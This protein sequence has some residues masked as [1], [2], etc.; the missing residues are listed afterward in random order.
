MTK[1]KIPN[2]LESMGEYCFDQCANLREVFIPYNVAVI[3][4][5]AFYNCQS[6]NLVEFN[7]NQSTSFI[8]EEDAFAY[9]TS[10][11]DMY[12]PANTTRIETR[13]FQYA[14]ISGTMVL[15]N[16]IT[17]FGDTDN[18]NNPSG[19]F[20][21]ATVK[22][23]IFY[24]N[25][26]T[27]S[28][29]IRPYSFTFFNLLRN[30]QKNPD[31]FLTVYGT[32]TAILNTSSNYTQFNRYVVNDCY[33]PNNVSVPDSII[34]YS[35]LVRIN[36][37]VGDLIVQPLTYTPNMVITLSYPTTNSNGGK[38]FVSL[39]TNICTFSLTNNRK[40][41]ISQAG[42]AI[43]EYRTAGTTIYLPSVTRYTLT[44]SKAFPTYTS[45]PQNT[46]L[47]YGTNANILFPKS[48]ST[49]TW[50]AVSSNTSICS[51]S[52]IT[53]TSFTLNGLHP[54]SVDIIMTQSSTTNYEQGRVMFTATIV[55]ANTV[56]SGISIASTIAYRNDLTLSLLDIRGGVSSNNPSSI[57]YSITDSNGSASDIASIDDATQTISITGT[58]SYVF[59][60]SQP[61]T[62]THN[63]VIQHYNVTVTAGTPSVEDI[64]DINCT[65]GDDTF[66]IN[67][68][69]S[70]SDGEWLILGINN[71]IINIVEGYRTLFEIKKAGAATITIRQSST[72]K[73]NDVTKY[74]K[75]NVAK[76]D[77]V[78]YWVYFSPIIS[79]GD[80]PCTIIE[81]DTT[82]TDTNASFSYATDNTRISYVIDIIDSY[83]QKIPS[84]VN[85]D[86][87]Q[88]TLTAT[89][90]ETD[91][92][93]SA[94]VTNTFNIGKGTTQ[95]YNYNLP[96]NI[97]Y[98]QGAEFQ[99]PHP[100]T[101]SNGL[102]SYSVDDTSIATIDNNNNKLII[103]KPGT[104]NVILIIEPTNRYNGTTIETLITILKT[105]ARITSISTPRFILEGE[106]MQ[107][108]TQPR[109]N[110]ISD[111][112]LE[113]VYNSL[114]DSIVDITNGYYYTNNVYLHGVDVGNTD[115]TVTLEESDFYTS[116]TITNPIRCNADEPGY[117]STPLTLGYNQTVV[118]FLA[119]PNTQL[120]EIPDNTSLPSDTGLTSS[121]PT[122]TLFAT[123]PNVKLT[124]GHL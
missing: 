116:A 13:C 41:S 86:V 21:N 76:Q 17:T 54:G 73:W 28:Q 95:V 98:S 24:T 63:S 29:A 55:K 118:S 34:P 92:F 18:R 39:T 60:A 80:S 26:N 66:D 11:V 8:F 62:G 27:I 36:P 113:F 22:N 122:Q 15:P 69:D 71:N 99:L 87:G 59:T 19:A 47:P 31:C 119:N 121:N 65:Y 40:L 50:T 101:N 109:T 110:V 68:P 67:F 9:C 108:S 97:G 93:N 82:N 124:Q 83:G 104:I 102:Y 88:V 106:T 46:T 52:N 42:T 103:L 111:S 74:I 107:L 45:V 3:R 77:P 117:N 81:P 90:S 14:N 75:V 32:T 6:L 85:R 4:K 58:G 38:T 20:S 25:S 105:P 94:S 10:L 12:L 51:V 70:P 112:N 64:A 48:D 89:C 2:T 123:F 44:I 37:T 30:Y 49:G 33:F 35:P 96:S 72:S 7:V 120:A 5:R 84:I 61:E 79:F 114:N 115:I 78:L 56:I 53:A 91:N 57:S 16:T 100:N 43:V 23:L 1:C